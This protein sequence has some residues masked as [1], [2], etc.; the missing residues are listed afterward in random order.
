MEQQADQPQPADDVPAWRS[1]LPYLAAYGAVVVVVIIGF[2][3]GIY[4]HALLKCVDDPNRPFCGVILGAAGLSS[5]EV[6]TSPFASGA[7]GVG[8]FPQTSLRIVNNGD[9]AGLSCAD[10]RFMRN[11][12][13]ARHGHIF[14]S[15]DMRDHFSAQPWYRPQVADATGRLTPVE[16]ENIALITK[17]E[18]ANKCR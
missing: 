13:Y 10:L 12:I 6:P 7:L 9:F 14:I 8:R 4:S 17:N 15:P 1:A 2:G 11:E 5:S 3:P 18:M 16:K